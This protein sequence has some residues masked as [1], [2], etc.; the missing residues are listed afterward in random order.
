[1]EIGASRLLQKKA[2]QTTGGK[3]VEVLCAERLARKAKE[4]QLR[5][6]LFSF[7]KGASGWE[8]AG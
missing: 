6:H 2:C 7:S 5:S 4:F 3:R 8:G 1:L